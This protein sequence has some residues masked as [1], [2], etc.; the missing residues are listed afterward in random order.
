MALELEH[1]TFTYA[2]AK[3]PAITGVSLRLDAGHFYG[4]IG[5]TG[6]GKTTL[7]N[8][9]TGIAP[10][11]L[12]GELDG[13]VRIEGVSTT[14]LSI[15][16]LVTRV[17][18]VFQNPFDQLS[19]ITYTVEE[20]VAFGLQNLGVEVGEIR[21]RADWALNVLGIA[22]LRNRFPLDLSGGELQR[23]AVASILAMKPSVLV[24]DEPTSQLDPQ[25][26]REVFEAVAAMRGSG[27]TVV[28]VEH[29]I[30]LLATHVDELLV[31][32]RGRLVAL[33]SPRQVLGDPS[34]QDWEIE[35]PQLAELALRLGRTAAAG[36]LPF[37]VE[38]FLVAFHLG[39]K[40]AH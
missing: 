39:P 18:Y 14:Q 21:A 9:L 23:L 35:R 6:G 7:C 27:L 37:G 11:F 30:E 3:E 32:Q 29:K 34:V 16:E 10:H 33:G 20:E 24:L 36:P 25:G 12:K 19:H 8:L 1:A 22:A 31:M 4:I 17:G 38:E 13:E 28:M 15:E 5:S 2:G 26:T 40:D